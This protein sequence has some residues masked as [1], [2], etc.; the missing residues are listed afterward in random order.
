[1]KGTK[2]NMYRDDTNKFQTIVIGGGQAG[3]STGY[4]LAK[5]GVPFQI[6]DGSPR[7]GDAWRN[8]WDSLRLFNPARYAG[9][10]GMRFPA[11]GDSFPTKDQMA[12]YLLEYARRF[13]LP[14]QNGVKV[15]R[16]WKEGDRFIIAAGQQ[17]FE[18]GNVVI[19][20]SNYQIPRIPAF[21]RELHPEIAQL[22]AHQYRNPSQL[23]EGGVLVVGVGNSGAEIALEAVRSHST[24]ISGTE[25]GHIPW[26]IDSLLARFLLVRFVRFFGHHILTVK[27]PLGRKLRPKLL[28]TANPLVRVKPKDLAH[29]GIKRVAKVIGV[30]EGLPLLTGGRT[31]DVTNVIWCTGYQHGFPWIDLPIFGEDGEPVHESGIV[32]KVPGIYFVGLHFLH[33]MTSATLMGVG[34]DAERIAVAI[35]A[36]ASEER[37]AL[38][39]SFAQPKVAC[40]EGT[41]CVP[42]QTSL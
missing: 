28:M 4:H 39:P 32:E 22:H 26:P 31:L 9:L 17:R 41:L 30:K 23:R 1:M 21:A 27:T 38:Q 19:A 25:S 29:A 37:P 14:V 5:R 3:L 20:M 34:R 33:S 7:I 6:L 16:L 15:D 8:R 36:R 24:W 10:P 42:S 13:R 2:N 40:G 12:D 11:R 18:A 35:A